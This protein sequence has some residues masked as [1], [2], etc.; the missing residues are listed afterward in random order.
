MPVTSMDRSHESVINV[1]D[2]FAAGVVGLAYSV[3][4]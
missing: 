2:P 4:D 1:V 3:T